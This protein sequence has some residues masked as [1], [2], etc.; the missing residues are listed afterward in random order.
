MTL[1]VRNLK[2]FTVVDI[3]DLT[4]TYEE[5]VILKDKIETLI[6]MGENHLAIN[7]RNVNFI[8]SYFIKILSMT[9]K[10]LKSS[11]GQLALIEPNDITLEIIK[12]VNLDT[13]IQIFNNERIFAR[14]LG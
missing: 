8:H 2:T 12:V 4:Q 9:Y 7:L 3:Q 14:S 13:Y 10:K 5:V 6:A 1:T 11:G